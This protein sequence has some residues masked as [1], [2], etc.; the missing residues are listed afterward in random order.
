VIF[1]QAGPM[2]K[3]RARTEVN[4]GRDALTQVELRVDSGI[5]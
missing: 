5:R 2:E 1:T 4:V 3:D